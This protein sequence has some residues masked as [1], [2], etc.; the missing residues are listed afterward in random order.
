MN[1]AITAIIGTLATGAIAA[2]KET[3]QA[4]KTYIQRKIRLDAVH[5]PLGP[6]L[7]LELGNRP[8]P[9]EQ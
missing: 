7:G 3:Y 5:L 4:I 1:S 6:D 9:V 8:Q 2:L